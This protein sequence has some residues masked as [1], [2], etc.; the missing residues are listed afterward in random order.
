MSKKN[1]LNDID[2]D[3]NYLEQVKACKYRGSILRWDNSNEE[4]IKERFALGNKAS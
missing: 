3:S 4:E 1:G 2:I